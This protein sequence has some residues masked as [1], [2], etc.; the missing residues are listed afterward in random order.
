MYKNE[1]IPIGRF[2]KTSG[3]EGAL[4]ASF[5]IADPFML[6]DIKWVHLD[7]SPGELIPFA[8][9]DLHIRA[10]DNILISLGYIDSIEKAGSLAGLTLYIPQTEMPEV[11]EDEFYFH[12]IIGW[13]VIDNKQGEI[14]L[15]KEI[16]ENPAQDLLK[17]ESTKGDIFI[18]LH[19]D[20]ILEI[21]KKKK[22]FLMTLPEGLIELNQK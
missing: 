3:V 12:E 18:P 11:S 5:S 19:D 15:I 9:E 17:V 10:K 14:G 13:K 20:L 22:F 21:N 7:I 1:C 8:V 4:V 6:E 2:R 16:I